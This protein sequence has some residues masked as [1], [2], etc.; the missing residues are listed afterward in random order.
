MV[1]NPSLCFYR[2]FAHVEA[3]L[4]LSATKSQ[5]FSK[6]DHKGGRQ[7]FLKKGV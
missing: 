2:A 1:G 6:D 5:K 3:V 7:R 4:F